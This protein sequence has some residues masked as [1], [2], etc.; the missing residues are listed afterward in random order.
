[1]YCVYLGKAIQTVNPPNGS[2][3]TAQLGSDAVTEAKIADSAVES[4]HLNNNIISGQTAL[5]ATP[6]IQMNSLSQMQVRLKE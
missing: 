3:G 2:V 5:G 4:E 1:M 6:Q